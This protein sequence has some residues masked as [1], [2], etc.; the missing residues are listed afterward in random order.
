MAGSA[1]T[2][3][4]EG[5]IPSKTILVTA[6]CGQNARTDIR[7]GQ[8]SWVIDEPVSF[9][10][11]NTAPSPVEMLLG[12]IA[13]CIAAVG[14]LIAREMGHQLQSLAI[15]IEG[16][17]NSDLFF[18]KSDI[19]RAGFQEIRIEI[20]ASCSWTADERESWMEQVIRRCPVIDNLSL[21]TPMDFSFAD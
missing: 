9:G 4:R 2:G 6:S 5:L 7:S 19:E 3:R 11:D 18:G 13:G 12:S 16:D 8:F 17:V 14:Q 21:P 20:D 1:V 15:R 10:G